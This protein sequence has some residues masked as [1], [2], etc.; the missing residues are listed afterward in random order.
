MSGAADGE[1]AA[2]VLAGGRSSR[3]GVDKA[4]LDWHGCPLVH[5]VSGLLARHAAPVVVVRAGGQR[6]PEL[7][8]GVETAIDDRPGRGPLE[9]MAAGLRAVAGRRATAVVCATDLPFLHPA[10]VRALVARLDGH[11]VAVGVGAGH[12]HH[13][14]AVYRTSLLAAV[15]RLLAAGE[16]RVGGLLA[17]AAVIRVPLARL[18]HAE[19]VR[20]LNSPDDLAAALRAPAPRV[21]VAGPDAAARQVRAWTLGEALDAGRPPGRVQLNGM[22]VAVEPRLPL[23]DGDR[24]TL[25]PADG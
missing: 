19:A 23:V 9:G 14:A 25:D 1:P 22:P 13:L 20:G 11:E 15:E 17:G 10:F 16:R 2:V 24:L 18:P 7:P 21:E 3:M 5:R 12:V 4:A 8:P 6:L